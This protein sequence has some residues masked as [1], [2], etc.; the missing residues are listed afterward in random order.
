MGKDTA[1]RLQKTSASASL[2]KSSAI[3]S[4]FK[5]PYSALVWPGMSVL[6]QVHALGAVRVLFDPG[7]DVDALQAEHDMWMD[8]RKCAR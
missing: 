5:F 7:P 1:G 6:V 2:K 4:V 3:Q 8:K